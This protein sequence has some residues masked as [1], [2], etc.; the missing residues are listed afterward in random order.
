MTA[1]ARENGQNARDRLCTVRCF[2]FL[3]SMDF[4]HCE[5]WRSHPVLTEEG[6]AVKHFFLE[7]LQ[8]Q[9]NGRCDV[10]CYQLRDDQAANHHQSKWPARCAISTVTERDWQSTEE[11]GHRGHQNR[12]E[13]LQACVMDRLIV[14]NSVPD[15]LLGE[16]DDHDSVFLDDTHQHEHSNVGIQRSFSAEEP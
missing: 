10:E 5:C 9:V 12:A 3:V 8:V 14:F 15:S 13:T 7:L 1:K 16:V 4:L 2:I 11:G 6:E